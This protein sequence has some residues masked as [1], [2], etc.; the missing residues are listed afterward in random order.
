[1]G[2]PGAWEARQGP[3]VTCARTPALGFPRFTTTTWV[4]VQ[5]IGQME[6]DS[7]RHPAPGPV[8]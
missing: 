7:L 1:M 3:M 5:A 4:K 8:P 6:E 2:E